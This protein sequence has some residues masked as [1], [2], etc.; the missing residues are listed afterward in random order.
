MKRPDSELRH[1][2]LVFYVGDMDELHA[3]L[4]AF[5]ELSK[6]K[7][8]MLIDR[9]G[10]MVTV[11]GEALEASQDTISALVAGSFA[12]TKELA[13]LLGESE[14]S[15]MFHQ[16][17]RDSVHLELVGGRTLLAVVLDQR[18][19][20]GLVRF[21]ARE[22]TGRLRRVFDRIASEGRTGEL[23]TDFSAEGAAALDEIF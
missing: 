1:D 19:N 3:E 10:H 23:S 22:V 12:A 14:F 18:T 17:Q 7:S 9:D 15:S 6:A 4:D 8:A 16:G 21:Y 11:R 20:L 5:L 13:R 2:R